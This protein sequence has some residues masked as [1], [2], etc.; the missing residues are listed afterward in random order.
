MWQ[1][2]AYCE[3][4]QGELEH[5]NPKAR[6]KRTSKKGFV[7]QLTQLERRQRRIRL[8]RQKMAL[9]NERVPKNPEAHHHIGI[10]ENH[11]QRFGPFL[12]SHSGDPAVAVRLFN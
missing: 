2:R 7:R 9:G 3:P 11:P 6:Y 4:P 10:A 12:Q 5:R 1:L 8:I